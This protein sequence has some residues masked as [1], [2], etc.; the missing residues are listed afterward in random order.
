MSIT[1]Q[2]MSLSSHRDPPVSTRPWLPLVIYHILSPWVPPKMHIH[3]SV[4]F[5]SVCTWG[6][7]REETPQTFEPPLCSKNRHKRNLLCS[8]YLI[9][10]AKETEGQGQPDWQERGWCLNPG[11]LSPQ[12]DCQTGQLLS[13]VT[14]E[15]HFHGSFW[16]KQSS[17]SVA[18]E[19]GQ[20]MGSSKVVPESVSSPPA[21]GV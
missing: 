7:S 9:H 5:H 17:S 14:S 20:V 3:W 18:T 10:S 16:G 19:L 4:L 2:S 11:N 21:H 1:C 6:A 13:L 15:S 12:L 8:R